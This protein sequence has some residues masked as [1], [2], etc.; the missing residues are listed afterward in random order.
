MVLS[1][2]ALRNSVYYENDYRGLLGSP[3][4]LIPTV[5]EVRLVEVTEAEAKRLG[6]ASETT[7]TGVPSELGPGL[8]G[9]NSPVWRSTRREIEVVI[10][11]LPGQMGREIP[12]PL[13]PSELADLSRNFEGIEFGTVYRRRP[14]GGGFWILES[15]EAGEMGQINSRWLNSGDA[16]MGPHTHPP[17]G[18]FGRASLADRQSLRTIQNLQLQADRP[19]QK[20]ARIVLPDGSTIGFTVQS[21]NTRIPGNFYG[22]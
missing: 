9:T 10:E 6:L 1:Q 5:L 4:F 20:T 17:S 21:P 13:T 19:V 2:E 8:A 14:T 16:V 22:R 18:D 3:V 15:G 11:Q 12:R 7:R